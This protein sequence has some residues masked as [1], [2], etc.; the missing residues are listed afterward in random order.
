MHGPVQ[1][2]SSPCQFNSLRLGLTVFS[3]SDGHGPSPDGHTHARDNESVSVAAR[4]LESCTRKRA[5]GGAIRVPDA[6]SLFMRLL[7]M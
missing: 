2:E 5:I 6:H 7:A 3:S 1:G 4:G